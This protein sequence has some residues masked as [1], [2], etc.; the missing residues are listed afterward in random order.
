[1]FTSKNLNLTIMWKIFK[2]LLFL[3]N[4]TID[5]NCKKMLRT[6]E[7]KNYNQINTLTVRKVDKIDPQATK[8][9][10]ILEEY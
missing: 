1:M 6:L 9:L 10:I 5:L 8:K 4:S 2:G 3:R 7:M